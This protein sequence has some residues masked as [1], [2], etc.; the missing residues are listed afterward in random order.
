MNEMMALVIGWTLVGGF[1][2]T[3]VLTLLSLPG[4][5]RFADKKQQQKLFAAIVLELLVGGVGWGVDGLKFD[6]SDVGEGVRIQGKNEALLEFMDQNENLTKKQATN[7]TERLD[8]SRDP[9]IG[10]IQLDLLKTI[11]ELPPGTL[12]HA[13]FQRL[14]PLLRRQ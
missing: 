8:P 12:E 9:R 3:V 13:S 10:E 11:K 6:A 7:L 5:I 2:F 1:V 14:Q 4:W